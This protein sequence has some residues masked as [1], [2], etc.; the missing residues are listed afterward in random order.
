MRKVRPKNDEL[1]ELPGYYIR[2]LHQIAVGRFVADTEAFNITPLQW[3]ALRATSSEPELDQRTLA[4]R[5]GIDTSTI[6]GVVDRLER[7]GLIERRASEQDRRVRQLVVTA[8]GAALLKKI[9]P[10]VL[11]VQQWLMA[12]L[13]EADRKR[14]LDM[15]RTLVEAN[16]ES[17]RAP[18]DGMKPP[19]DVPFYRSTLQRTTMRQMFEAAVRDEAALRSALVDAD[20]GPMAMTLAHLSGDMALLDEVAP[21]IQGGWNYMQTVP[22]PLKQKVRDALVEVLKGYAASGRTPQ[23]VLPTGTL[24]HIMSGGVGQPIPPEY[25]PLVIEETRFGSNDTRALRWRVD[26]GRLPLDEFRVVIIGA[27]LSGICAGIRLKE[28]GIPFV[29]LEKNDTPGGTWFE[30]DYPGCGVDIPNYFYSYSFFTDFA[31]SRHFSKRDEILAYLQE[32]VDR[33]GIR[34]HIRFEVEVSSAVFHEEGLWH[35]TYHGG[36]GRDGRSEKTLANAVISAVG[37]LNRPAVPTIPGLDDFSGPR[38]HTARWD[39]SVELAG[40]RVAMIGTGASGMQV[41]PTIAPEVE[42]LTVFQRTP[43][44]AFN[45]PNYHKTISAGMKWTLDH[46]PFYAK[47]YRFSL[48]WAAS[49]GIHASL[50]VDPDWPK[51]SGAIN[52]ANQTM[53]EALIGHIAS[54]LDGDEALMAKVIPEYP[55]YGKRMLRDNH[56]YRMLKRPNVELVTGRID[57]IAEDGVVMDD[58]SSH[59]ADVIVFATG[60]QASRM[61]WPMDIRG[62]GGVTIR[63]VW[64]DDDPRAYLGMTAPGFPN[65]F[66]AYGP[67]TNLVH[68]GSIFF[69]AECQVNHIMQALREMI[70]QGHS[71]I[72]VRRRVHDDYNERVDQACRSL[73]WGQPSVNNW[74]QN[75]THRVFANSPWRLVDYWEM[76]RDFDPTDYMFAGELSGA[77]P[78]ASSS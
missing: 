33:F 63:E 26:K 36:D 55:P 49:D 62:R 24:V 57:H 72:E 40:K 20:I 29:I 54:E 17:S 34:E 14:F 15:L 56:W 50:K 18:S 19:R 10:T 8:E 46:V 31:W 27:G 66:F 3:A 71:T 43:H 69:Q 53:R 68:G 6:A 59:P 1:E 78:V 22:E 47:W 77:T 39:N 5:I 41:G 35:V 11:G 52:R 60:F 67:N 37:Q 74:Y 9:A 76:T 28:A 30:N 51:E 13:P 23:E 4:R 42:K 75:K 16:A 61:Q 58:G 65:L 64:G 7:R 73:S 45:H 70:E 38:F 12:P 25:V 32:A 44:W 21:H 48:F 2:R